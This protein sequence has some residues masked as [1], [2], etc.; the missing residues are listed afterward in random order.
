MQI[1]LVYGK[2]RKELYEFFRNS[3]YIETIKKINIIFFDKE[4]NSYSEVTL[5][6]LSGNKQDE[7][8]IFGNYG[9]PNC[10]DHILKINFKEI[11]ESFL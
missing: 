1:N 8:E 7:I 11:E 10:K 2:I 9:S 6:S 5:K 4:Y 3:I